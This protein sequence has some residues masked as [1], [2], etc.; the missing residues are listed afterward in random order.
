MD[1]AKTFGLV[2]GFFLYY[3]VDKGQ[4]TSAILDI[5]GSRGNFPTPYRFFLFYFLIKVMT[6]PELV[7]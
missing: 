2:V 4:G 6:H 7:I 3:R 5:Y 1:L